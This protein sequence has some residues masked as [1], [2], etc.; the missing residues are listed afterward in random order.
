MVG[1]TTFVVAHRLS[2]IRRADQIVVLNQGKI[3]EVGT[4][5]ELLELEG[6]YASLHGLQV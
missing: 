3:V 6:L 4:H 5:P 2:T 1:R